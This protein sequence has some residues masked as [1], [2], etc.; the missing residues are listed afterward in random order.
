MAR[1]ATPLDFAQIGEVF[2]D[3]TIRMLGG[4]DSG[5]KS[6]IL[7]DLKAVQTNLAHLIATQPDVFTGES[8][9]H[10]Q[11]IV[12]QIGL[13]RQAI[14]TIGKDPYAAKYINDVQRDLIDIVQG[15]DKL[16]GL[17]TTGNSNGFA[18]LPEPLAAP[19]PFAGNPQQVAFMT[20]F[21]ADAA[22][23]SQ[24]ATALADAG[25]TANSAAGATLAAAVKVFATDAN[26]FSVAQGGLYSAR[27]NN[28]FA[29]QGVN[30]TASRA[31]EH[32]LKTGNVDEVKAAAAVLAA[33]ANDVASNMLGA[34]A[35]PADPATPPVATPPVAAADFLK[36]VTAD[37]N[38]LADKAVKLV[39][40]GKAGD[41]P[42]TAQLT[43]DI[44]KFVANAS[45][46]AKAQ[47]GTFAT[48]VGKELAADGAVGKAVTSLIDGLKAGNDGVV[49]KAGD[50]LKA[51]AVTV[52]Q[53]GQNALDHPAQAP[54]D[55]AHTGT[56]P[57]AADF[58]KHLTADANALGDKAVKLVDS[59]KA[60]DNAE[61][62]KLTAEIQKF[63]ADAATFAKAQGG[64]FATDVGK[65]LTAD[66]AI[67]KATGFL[68]G[69]LKAGDD[70]VVDH[71][72]DVLK[73]NTAD[74]A[75][76][77]QNALDHPAQ[78]PVDPAPA[79]TP[80][81]AADF[82]KQVTA[83]ANAL[84]DKAV[85]LVDSGKAGDNPATA[86]LT[87]DIQKFVANANDAA[88]A[89][90]GTFATD[91]GKELAA[92][93]AV[94]KAVTS[95]I[96]GLKAGNDGV[97]DKAG[98]ALKAA[99]VTVAQV[100]Q[101]ALDH[102]AQA[103][104]DPA[105]ADTPP[106][107]VGSL[108]D[109]GKQ[110]NDATTKLVGGVYD[111]TQN[112]GNR[113]AILNDL[114]GAQKAVLAVAEHPQGLSAESLLHVRMVADQLTLEIDAVSKAG[115]GKFDATHINDIH[116]EV[117]SIVQ[118]DAAL[119]AA[120]STPDAAGFAGFT[121]VTTEAPVSVNA[122]QA[123]FAND[124][125][126]SAN[127]LGQS[128]IDLVK[129]D[130]G[131]AAATAQLQQQIQTFAEKS[132]AFSQAQGDK[133]AAHF[134]NELSINGVNGTAAK[135]L[136]AALGTHDAAQVDAAAKLLSQNAADVKAAQ[137][138]GG[139]G[140]D[141]GGGNG[142]G[143]SGHGGGQAGHHGNDHEVAHNVFGGHHEH[144]WG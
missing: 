33:N 23:L 19:T 16:V 48:D 79:A 77:A 124:F 66:G 56:A 129:A 44:Q 12:D 64:T 32:G 65:E 140:G 5:N 86:Q 51:A 13:E 47:G 91:V 98:D 118:G 36:Q 8:R 38:A 74:V 127:K 61:T 42:A 128:A 20:K 117:I 107:A 88:K 110:F 103:P 87:A 60:G 52:A 144:M 95:L 41:N 34:V 123:A 136:I 39:D 49:D 143:N 121:H 122:K 57:A 92:D 94:G 104:A 116:R 11:N 130:P 105:P 114:A 62:A 125:V 17:A 35:T 10:A 139:N 120:S 21:A 119:Q 58:V 2:N 106:V 82:L 102:P 69:G 73:A 45:D 100:G 6:A 70:G 101:N 76:I 53:V 24:Q 25:L 46:A 31:L 97:V 50:A 85:T 22:S 83:D 137:V 72:A 111:G 30:G 131:N 9:I 15:D 43:A 28:E 84:A 71:W 134:D 27:F 93:G 37:A 109:A 1:N 29:T 89:Q 67:G 133:Y 96:D 112:D 126:T 14:G 138:Q 115:T 80:V 99:A 90:G 54:A 141:A 4:I 75:K 26:H 108:V 113:A 78:T 132:S 55:P 63:V 59:G 7:Q 68:I 18:A 142:G 40:S 135:A 81:A 3:A